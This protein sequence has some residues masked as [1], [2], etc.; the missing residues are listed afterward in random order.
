MAQ[1]Q[2][3]K[4]QIMKH[5]NNQI[6]LNQLNHHSLPSQPQHQLLFLDQVARFHLHNPHDQL[7]DHQHQYLN[8]LQLHVPS[9]D[10]PQS[11]ANPP[12]SNHT[13][14]FNQPQLPSKHTVQLQLQLQFPAINQPQLQLQLQSDDQAKLLP[15]D[16]LLD[17]SHLQ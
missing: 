6:F 1:E 4:V 5:L 17:Q 13:D 3:T 14:Q 11:T 16:L 15:G 8:L 12:L 2:L 9:L 10:Q 7:I